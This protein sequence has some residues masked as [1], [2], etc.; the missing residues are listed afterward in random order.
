MQVI[1]AAPSASVQRSVASPLDISMNCERLRA[2]LPGMQ[3]T[4]FCEVRDSL[5]RSDLRY[6]GSSF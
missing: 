4:P 3:L 2:A 6:G 1:V 5:W